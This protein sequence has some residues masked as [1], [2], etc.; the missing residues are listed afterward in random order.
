MD[1]EN[2]PSFEGHNNNNY[3]NNNRV[4]LVKFIISAIMN[5]VIISCFIFYSIK[6]S[7]SKK[8]IILNSYKNKNSKQ[9]NMFRFLDIDD[10][11]SRLEKKI[12][13]K[14]RDNLIEDEIKK[15]LNL[16]LEN[17]N[18]GFN[19]FQEVIHVK[20]FVMIKDS[21]FEEKQKHIFLY[22]LIKNIYSG[23]WEYYPYFDDEEESTKKNIS[24]LD[25]YYYLNS[26]QNDFK[27][28]NSRNGSVNF[29]FKKAIEMA[30]KQEALSLSMKNLEGDYI[31]NW[32][33]HISYIKM[34]E[35]NRTVDKENEIFKLKGE[36]TTSL[37]KGKLFN[38]KKKNYR[39]MHCSTLIEIEFPL[40]EV[41]LTKTI[42]NKNV[43][44]KHISTIDPSNFTMILSSTCGFRIKI[45]AQIYD[46][47][48]EYSDIKKKINFFCYYSMIGSLLYLL[49]A[50]CL[51]HSLQRNENAV[52][53]ISLGSF[54]Q[55]IA[56]HSYC[57]IN[58]IHFGLLYSEYFLHFCFI[59]IFPFINF[60]IFDIRFLFCYWRIK[61]RVVNNRQYIFLRLKFF[62]L[63]YGLL[64]LSFF[65]ISSFYINKMNITI[66]ALAIWTPQIIYNM[67]HNNKYLYPTFYILCTT[68]ER[69]M[70]PFYFRGYKNNFMY[71]KKDK[72]LFIVLFSYILISII[73]L[74]LQGFLGARFMLPA[75]FQ[76]KDLKFY[77]TK[78]EI[79]KERPDCIKEECVICISPLIEMDK[80][81][82]INNNNSKVNIII[83]NNEN[84]LKNISNR[85]LSQ[86]NIKNE[87]TNRS[88]N[89]R[90][91]LINNN[92][93]NIKNNNIENKQNLKNGIRLIK[94][95]KR[96]LAINVKRK[97][98]YP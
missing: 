39:Q 14:Q 21:Y 68:L 84:H 52:S 9:K 48:K 66:L 74:Y 71:L 97:K 65:S 70:L 36:F 29:F 98:K 60:I 31:D 78:E 12:I 1:N 56:W 85:S 25:E 42:E 79:L 20:P 3:N 35:L 45:K 72:I 28:G 24:E 76:K 27:I 75:R 44:N 41:K 10:I 95:H 86:S 67:I 58:S 7:I 92:N 89:N 26:S 90:I 87:N 53:A 23:T 38:N 62:A 73:I 40:T 30:S 82:N 93:K 59:S 19:S 80:K 6:K 51:T 81:N 50:A 91:N 57:G 77:K 64:F 83:N 88:V 37:V 2:D 43:I 69:I 17:F 61:R 15:F 94:N 96:S 18:N 34:N 46:S 8:F 63:F 5:I 11:F 54:C 13:V 55:N 47:F 32:I 49:G 22:R 4:F 16:I 33:E